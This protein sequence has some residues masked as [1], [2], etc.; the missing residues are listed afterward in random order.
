MTKAK[1]EKA[2]EGRVVNL[3]VSG[4]PISVSVHGEGKCAVVLGPGA[5]G[6]RSTPQLLAAAAFLDPARYIS[7]TRK[8]EGS[9]LTPPRCA[10]RP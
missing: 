7:P 4:K 6:T 10:S 2:N 1:A 8:R 9:S 5:G 3:E